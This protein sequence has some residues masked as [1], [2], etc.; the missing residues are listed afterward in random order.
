MLKNK[1]I[2]ITGANGG[3]GSELCKLLNKEGAILTKVVSTKKDDCF[4]CDFS[5]LEGL[6]NLEKLLE[7][8]KF[9]I[10]IN[11]AGI[12]NFIEFNKQS[13]EEIIN[14][15]NINLTTAMLI[16]KASLNGFML[17]QNRGHIINV[18]SVLGY[19][20]MPFYATY[21]ASKAGLKAFSEAL[22]RELGDTNIK[23]S[24]IAPRAVNTNINSDKAMQFMKQTN[25]NIDEPEYVANE[26]LKVI[27]KPAAR[28]II[29]GS[30]SIFSKINILIP[31]LVDN[32]M[33]KKLDLAK[34][35]LNKER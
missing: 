6:K 19:I 12:N 30:E 26:I 18:G 20:P 11:L 34:K 35:I 16:A 9:D 5:K 14:T 24:Y 31:G 22:Y 17:Q 27:K 8:E 28:T 33:F 4:V 2:L 29:G 10:V 7:S 1:K 32:D 15:I 3:I 25:A 13:D 23:I 21:C